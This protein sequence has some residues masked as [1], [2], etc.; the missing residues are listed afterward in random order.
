MFPALPFDIIQLLYGWWKACEGLTIKLL[1]VADKPMRSANCGAH[2]EYAYWRAVRKVIVSPL[3]TSLTNI[4]STETV[5]ANEY[6]HV[7]MILHDLPSERNA[8]GCYY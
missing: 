7:Y 5:L 3:A 6:G 4:C 8:S 1:L 2:A